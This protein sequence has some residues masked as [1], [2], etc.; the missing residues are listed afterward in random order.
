M[1]GLLLYLN[2]LSNNMFTNSKINIF[3]SN[4]LSVYTI[5]RS[6]SPGCFFIGFKN[7][8]Y[9]F[10][11]M[12][13]EALYNPFSEFICSCSTVWNPD[14]D[15]MKTLLLLGVKVKETLTEDKRIELLKSNQEIVEFGTYIFNNKEY[16]FIIDNL[17]REIKIIHKIKI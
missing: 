4:E 11:A 10:N 2:K 1:K 13:I 9:T 6:L 7:D 5:Y 16:T 8:E 15:Q 14:F 17:Q 12:I 3:D